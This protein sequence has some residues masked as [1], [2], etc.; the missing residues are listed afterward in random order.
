MCSGWSSME[1]IME[2]KC[3]KSCII[4]HFSLF[5]PYSLSSLCLDCAFLAPLTLFST[6]SMQV[7]MVRKTHLMLDESI[8]A[9]IDSFE[10]FWKFFLMSLRI[11]KMIQLLLKKLN[12]MNLRDSLMN[13]IKYSRALSLC[14]SIWLGIE[15]SLQPSLLCRYRLMMSFSGRINIATRV[16]YY[17]NT[18]RSTS[19]IMIRSL[20][21]L[22]SF[23]IT[24][25]DWLC[26]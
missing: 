5:I 10:S 1:R 25:F 26:A 17:F 22:V 15:L 20:S 14:S 9:K 3:Y 16:L 19:I 18:T 21:T 6:L 13:N 4:G 8:S 12:R 7:L 24:F 2:E 11:F 23:E